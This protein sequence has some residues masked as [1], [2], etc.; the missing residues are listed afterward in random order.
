MHYQMWISERIFM[1]WYSSLIEFSLYFLLPVIVIITFNS[2]TVIQIFKNSN[3]S[4]MAHALELN[5]KKLNRHLLVVTLFVSFTFLISISLSLYS[6]L[7][8]DLF[9]DTD[10]FFTNTQ[11]EDITSTIMYH[12]WLLNHAIN[13][14]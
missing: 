5:R 7:R 12:L 2:A 9:E 6:T 8:P 13:F 11:T 10:Y 3:T 1:I 14:F 4:R